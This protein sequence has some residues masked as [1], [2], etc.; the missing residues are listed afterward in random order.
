MIIL[1]QA[2]GSNRLLSLTAG[3]SRSQNEILREEG[4]TVVGGPRGELVVA[5]QAYKEPEERWRGLRGP[6]AIN[7]R[8][9]DI[10]MRLGQLRGEV[11]EVGRWAL[12]PECPDISRPLKR[13]R[14]I[15]QD[16]EREIRQ[17]RQR[18]LHRR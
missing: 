16:A 7:G 8:L 5:D 11:G 14:E 1:I 6:A 9:S 18:R 17:A 2:A 3:R 15:L 13:V 10:E 12:H 4:K